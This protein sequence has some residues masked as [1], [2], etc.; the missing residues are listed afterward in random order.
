MV[1]SKAAKQTRLGAERMGVKCYREKAAFGFF[2]NSLR[3][4]LGHVCLKCRRMEGNTQGAFR[5][6]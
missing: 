4:W 3:F 6:H 2:E 1:D 5:D